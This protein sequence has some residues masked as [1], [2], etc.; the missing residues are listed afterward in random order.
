MRDRLERS[1][2]LRAQRQ[3]L[4]A[5]WPVGEPVH[6]LACEHEAHGALQRLG[7]EHGEHDLI[8]RPQAGAEAAAHIGR[9][10]A[11]IVRLHVEDAAEILLHVLDALGLVIDGELAA[12]LPDRGRG[13][14]FHRIVVLDRNEIFRLVPHRCGR[15]GLLGFAA[16]LLRLLNLHR[17]VAPGEEVGRERFGF[18]FHGH[19][20]GRKA[21]DFPF[22]R[23]NQSDRLPVEQ[24]LVVIKRAQRRALLGGDVVLVGLR[25]AGHRRP[26]LVG[27]NVENAFDTQ[28]F[29][30]V[31]AGDTAF[32]DRSGDDGRVG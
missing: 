31:D 6:L 4:D 8:L 24:D 1:V 26:V 10:H 9:Q 7:A 22:L 20:R 21:R 5:R 13:V 12:A 32:G 27:E 19:Q 23:Q 15:K 18:V 17:L 2:P 28:R 30:H 11:H 3:S 25:G 29:T 16:R 14:Q